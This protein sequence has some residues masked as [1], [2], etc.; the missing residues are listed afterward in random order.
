MKMFGHNFS[1][2]ERGV[3]LKIF[4][5]Q[6]SGTIP[7]CCDY[8]RCETCGLIVYDKES[9]LKASRC[10]GFYELKPLDDTMNCNNCIIRGI[11]E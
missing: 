4:H 5:K 7:S 3:V 11:I 9:Q 1:P 10:N 6:G 2:I 8:Y